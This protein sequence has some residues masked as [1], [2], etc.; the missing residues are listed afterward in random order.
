[1]LEEPSLKV[2]LSMTVPA[3]VITIA[4]MYPCAGLLGIG[5]SH[6]R[7]TVISSALALVVATSSP[8]LTMMIVLETM[9]HLQPSFRGNSLRS[10]RQIIAVLP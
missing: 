4:M 5:R 9:T 3:S 1:M 8:R 2:D 6:H 10:P 7:P